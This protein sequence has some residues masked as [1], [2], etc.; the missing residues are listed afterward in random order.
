MKSVVPFSALY[1]PPCNSTE[2]LLHKS[3]LI[4]WTVETDP[5]FPLADPSGNFSPTTGEYTIPIDGLYTLIVQLIPINGAPIASAAKHRQNVHYALRLISPP[6]SSSD[7]ADYVDATYLDVGSTNFGE[8]IHLKAG[9]RVACLYMP[10]ARKTESVRMKIELIQRKLKRSKPQLTRKQA[11]RRRNQN[12]KRNAAMAM[13]NPGSPVL[14]SVSSISSTVNSAPASIED[15]DND[16]IDYEYDSWS[17][18][19]SNDWESGFE[20]DSTTDELPHSNRNVR[21]LAKR[22]RAAT[23]PPSLTGN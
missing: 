15:D 7:Q 21:R 9:T 17:D 8:L 11:K 22:F 13:S 23:T 16:F 20:S 14:T 5:Q 6:N 3:V 12:R 4:D 18:S 19:D 10:G 1:L 2:P